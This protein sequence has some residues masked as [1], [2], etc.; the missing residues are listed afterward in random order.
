MTVL[1]TGQ[2]NQ[3]ATQITLRYQSAST[4]AVQNISDHVTY[5][6]AA[7][8]SEVEANVRP[9]LAIAVEQYRASQA[10]LEAARLVGQGQNGPAADVLEAQARQSEQRARSIGGNAAAQ[11]R[12]NNHRLNNRSGLVRNARGRNSR[13][14]QLHLNYEAMQGQGFR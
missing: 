4:N 10:Q 11:I 7:S 13:A 5:S 6:L 9:E 1:T 8:Q 2:A 3:S 14:Q 12:R